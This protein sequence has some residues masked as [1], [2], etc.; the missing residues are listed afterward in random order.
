MGMSADEVQ[1]FRES[2]NLLGADELRAMIGSGDEEDAII[3]EILAGGT[4]KEMKVKPDLDDDDAHPNPDDK[5]VEPARAKLGEE[6]E[7]EEEE[8]DDPATGAGASAPG[9]ADAANAGGA[10]A[11]AADA[12]QIAPLDLAFLDVDFKNRLL[13]MDAENKKDFKAMME[14]ELDPDEYA[15]RNSKYLNDRD[16][17]RDQ[18]AASAAFF[19]DV[20]NFKVQ[21]L[22]SG[23]NYDT[24]AEKAAAWDD[25]VKR[26][27][28][29]PA[30]QKMSDADILAAA[31]RKVLVEFDVPA[32]AGA[33]NTGKDAQNS[34]KNVSGTKKVAEKQGRAPNLS[35]I[36]PTLGGIP[37]AATSDGQDGGEFAHLETLSGMD[38]ERAIARLSPEQ[39]DRYGAM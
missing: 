28:A 39:R 8:E 4:A 33:S 23:V 35:N 16:G 29:S 24:D 19:T 7:E 12:G 32:A 27:A 1:E 30:G 37:A 10:A 26:I 18:K 17:L 3:N 34:G 38:F 14:G 15:E 21:A 2:A 31:H 36:P 13:A 5:R 9:A 11:G 20:H 6:E 25:W 22:A